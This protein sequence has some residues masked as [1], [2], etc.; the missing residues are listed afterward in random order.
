[1]KRLWNKQKRHVLLYD[2][3]KIQVDFEN[4]KK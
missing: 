3:D 2:T 1:M 4:V